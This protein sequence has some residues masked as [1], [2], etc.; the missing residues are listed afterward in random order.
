MNFAYKKGNICS[1]TTT[2]PNE[3]VPTQSPKGLGPFSPTEYPIIVLD[4]KILVGGRMRTPPPNFFSLSSKA[5]RILEQKWK[6]KYS[7]ALNSK[8]QGGRI[9]TA[10]VVHQ[11]SG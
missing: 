8:P 6:G 9:Q 5:E 4:E 7:S 1:P 2:F 3:C 10:P 11:P